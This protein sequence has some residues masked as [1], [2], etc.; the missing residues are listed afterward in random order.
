VLP[1]ATLQPWLDRLA[2]QKRVL[3]CNPWPDNDM[4][5]QEAKKK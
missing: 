2:A 3:A 4:K 5:D 1:S